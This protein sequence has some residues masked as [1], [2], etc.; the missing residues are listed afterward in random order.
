MEGFLEF[1]GLFFGDGSDVVGFDF[2]GD[3]GVEVDV[4][5]HDSVVFFLG[6]FVVFFDFDLRE[7][8]FFGDF[9][10]VSF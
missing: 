4:S 10:F 7:L 9:L 5:D 2:G 6:G 1:F 8:G 3:F